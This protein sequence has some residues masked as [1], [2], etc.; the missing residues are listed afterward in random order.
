MSQR[1]REN[2]PTVGDLRN[3]LDGRLVVLEPLAAGHELGLFEAAR[4]GSLFEWMPE[5]LADS[6]EQIRNW[7]TRSIKAAEEGREVP[8]AILEAR[9]GKPVG[10][11]RFLEIRLEH[12]R[13]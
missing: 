11:T 5:T 8:F 13:V 10:S 6:R 3:R 7:M 4:D 12:L 9:S 1:A 2:V